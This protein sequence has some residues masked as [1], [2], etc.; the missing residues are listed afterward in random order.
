MV[1][2][3]IRSNK[4]GT[5][6]GT[7]DSV[8]QFLISEMARSNVTKFF[9]FYS[10]DHWREYISCSLPYAEPIIL[11]VPFLVQAAYL[12]RRTDV[13]CFH[14]WQ[15]VLNSELVKGSWTKEVK[16]K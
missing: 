13:Q 10:L 11:L 6:I 2:S 14:H 4:F 12:P 3:N 7:D 5:G 15:K 9:V 16:I 8:A 1:L